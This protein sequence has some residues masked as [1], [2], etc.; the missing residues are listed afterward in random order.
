MIELLNSH[1]FVEYEVDF[2]ESLKNGSKSSIMLGLCLSEK[3]DI[4]ADI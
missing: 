4:I 2:G 1:F 3:D